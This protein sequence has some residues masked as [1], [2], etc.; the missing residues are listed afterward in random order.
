MRHLNDA[1]IAA[2]SL[3]APLISAA[4][5]VGIVGLFL[6][7][8]ADVRRM[9]EMKRRATVLA[10]Q[11]DSATIDFTQAHA[12]LYRA[13]SLKSQGVE[14][15]II[16][17]A[18]QSALELVARAVRTIDDLGG[19]ALADRRMLDE[20]ARALAA[21]AKAAKLTADVV[22]DDAFVAAMDM[23]DAQ[24]QFS[25]AKKQ[26][27]PLVIETGRVRDRVDAEAMRVLGRAVYQIGSA[28]GAA[29]LLS[30][31]AALFFGWLVSAPIKAMTAIMKRLASG[32][33]TVAIPGRGRRD[34]VGAM[35]Q[36]VEVFRDNAREA[37]RLGDEQGREQSEKARRGAERDELVRRFGDEIAQVIER[38]AGEAGGMRRVVGTLSAATAAA[39]ER[40]SI[41]A[42]ASEEASENVQAVA[43][44]AEELAA[45]ISE[46]NRQVL[47]S[48]DV[49]QRAVEGARRTSAVVS[50]L[51]HGV[52]KIGDV[53]ALI[54]GIASQTNLLALNATIEAARAGAAG[55]G[56]AVVAGEVKTLAAQTAQ[57]TEDIT[58]QI[59]GI[60]ASTTDAVAAIER[61]GGVIAEVNE[62]AGRISCAV[63]QQGAATQ[64]IA[65]NVQ[66]A[67]LGTQQ[68]SSNIAGVNQAVGD[69]QA[70]VAQV[71]VA[72]EGVSAQSSELREH[73]DR[74]R[75]GM[76]AA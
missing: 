54:S 65:R 45:S 73:F 29:I 30:L 44:A 18:K 66:Q 11:A 19:N 7:V 72:A 50:T 68:V 71:R 10:A 52:Q 1:S 8:H 23:N 70:V 35:A 6:S 24:Q 26:I 31:A 25:L 64:E 48:A 69:S 2:K 38:L 59:A 16:K 28:A 41:V 20:V 75:R 37:R 56:F 9:D 36:A 46:I 13:V 60:Q 51:A 40:S 55:K 67:A 57:A 61:I 27:D 33:L 15:R 76:T 74:F 63:E 14:T 32:E 17:E 21:Y 3:I 53:V 49:A 42:S 4:I 43:S 39:T 12:D 58:R 22:E 34:E 62:I 5:L 47:V